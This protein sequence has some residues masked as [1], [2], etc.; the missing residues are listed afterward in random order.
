MKIDYALMS[1]NSN[2]LYLNF[3]PVVSKVWE[4]K[5]NIRPILIYVDN[6][7]INIS[8]EFGE[9]IKL[10]PVKGI[11]DIVQ[12]QFAR[13]WYSQ[14]FKD[15]ICIISDIDMI[16]LSLGYFKTQFSPINDNEYVITS[17]DGNHINICYNVASGNN[18]KKYLKL[19]DD[20]ESQINLI[21]DDKLF[22]ENNEISWSA[23]EIFLT[24]QLKNKSY[25]YLKRDLTTT[26]IDRSKWEY[27][28]GKLKLGMYY[29]CHSIRPYDTHKNEID[30]LINYIL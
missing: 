10:K 3:W 28:I 21:K 14:F 22:Y 26:R 19:F 18:F 7:D 11:N 5:F 9:V 30:K 20:W 27:D 17:F 1:C 2:P 8:E 6:V 29:D 12:S 25:K 4:Q 16:P 13:L 15:S 23:D 24:K